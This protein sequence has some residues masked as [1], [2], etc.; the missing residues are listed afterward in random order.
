MNIVSLVLH[1]GSD[2]FYCGGNYQTYMNL[3]NT[4]TFEFVEDFYLKGEGLVFWKAFG[5]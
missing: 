3:Y 4:I 2:I 5:S 1:L